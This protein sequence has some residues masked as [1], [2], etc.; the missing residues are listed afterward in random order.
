MA[1]KP[2]VLPEHRFLEGYVYHPMVLSFQLD[3]SGTSLLVELGP[4]M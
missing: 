3:C 2:V 4:G 1:W